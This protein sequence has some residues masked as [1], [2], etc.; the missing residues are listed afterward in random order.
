MKLSS[1]KEN[2]E[3]SMRRKTELEEQALLTAICEAVEQGEVSAVACLSEKLINELLQK[4]YDV[5][6][7]EPGIYKIY[8]DKDAA[9]KYRNLLEE[10]ATF[11]ENLQKKRRKEMARY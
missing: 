10:R 8:W 4:G 6:M 5:T 3:E 7:T 11:E 1:A 2:Y 9:G